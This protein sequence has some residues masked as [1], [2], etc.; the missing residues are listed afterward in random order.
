M[1]VGFVGNQS[2]WKGR[3]RHA[4]R[5]VPGPHRRQP[6]R[7]R[8]MRDAELVSEIYS[9]REL[10]L[11]GPPGHGDGYLMIGDAFGFVDPMFSTG[12]LMAMT[13]GSSARRR[14]MPGSTTRSTARSSP[15]A[16]PRTGQAMDRIGWLIYRIND[17]VHALHVL[18]RRATYFCM[19]DGII[20]MLAGNLR[21]NLRSIVPVLMFKAAYRLLS[22]LH[23]VRRRAGDAGSHA[24]PCGPCHPRR[25][26]LFEGDGLAD[27]ASPRALARDDAGLQDVRRFAAWSPSPAVQ[28]SI[29]LHAAALGVVATEPAGW[30]GVTGLI[31]ANHAVLACGMRPR[32]AMLG[33]N[34]TRVAPPAPGASDAVVLTFDDGPDPVVTPRV[35]DLLDRHGAKASF[36][37]LGRLAAQHPEI[38]RDIVARGHSVEN[39][40]HRHP[41][42]FAGWLPGAM[43]REI[44]RAQEAIADACGQAPQYFRRRPGCAVRCSTRCWPSP[45]CAWS[46]GP[47][48]AT[49]RCR[50]A[51]TGSIAGWCGTSAPATSCCCM[52]AAPL[53]IAWRCRCCPACW[54][55]SGRQASA[56]YRC[57]RPWATRRTAPQQARQAAQHADHK[58]CMH[59]GQPDIVAHIMEVRDT[60]LARRRGIAPARQCSI[61][62][63][64]RQAQPHRR[65]RIEV[66]AAHPALPLHDVAQRRH[67]IDAEAE[68]RIAD[69][70]PQRLQLRPPLEIRRPRTRSRGAWLEYRLAEPWRPGARCDAAMKSRDQPGRVLAVGIHRERVGEAGRRRLAQ[71]VQHRGALALVVRQHEDRRPGSSCGRCLQRRRV[72]SVLPS[73]TTQTGST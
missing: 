73:T 20:N 71:P 41:L 56:R 61:G 39:H 34:L 23:Q 72:P 70:A 28:A 55:A 59:P 44:R 4:R 7:G 30:P 33:S 17:P 16:R 22:T 47:G 32:S 3:Q 48:V 26:N 58:P 63:T 60:A 12:V 53:W 52:T 38:L 68:E 8:R 2:A 54:H 10:Q 69:A 51:R 62:R 1:S 25:R 46:P 14:R 49:T 21:L 50:R 6:D 18:A 42:S 67:R 37:V 9:H 11:P 64:P 35:L 24:R 36:F 13:A 19:R 43:L 15:A 45:A 27:V 65:L 31:A 29:W 57:A 40:T 66:E 5:P